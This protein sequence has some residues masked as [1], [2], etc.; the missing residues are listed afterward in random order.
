MRLR[1]L[2]KGPGGLKYMFTGGKGG[3][4][5]TVLA[6]GLAAHFAM[7]GEKTLVASLNPV[8]SLSSLFQQELTGGHVKPVRGLD[9]LYAIEVEID[10]AV[11]A[12]RQSISKRLRE[13]LKWAEIPLNPE[14]FIDIATTN[15]AFHE[16]AMF[17]KTM[18]IVTREAG[19]YS[20]IIFDTAAVANAVRLIGLSKIYGLWLRRMIESRKE[21]MSLR[22]Q[23]S[24]KKDKVAEEIKRDPLMLDLIKMNERFTTTRKILTNPEETAFFFVT[25]P[26][27]LPIS[28]VKRFISMVKAFEI[29][30]GGV[31]VNQI[32]PEQA[33]RTDG[34]GFLNGKREEQR[35]YMQMIEDDMGDLV[36]SYVRMFPREIV[37]LD[38]ITQVVDDM[39]NYEPEAS[40][41][42]RLG[43]DAVR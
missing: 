5:K 20:R 25:T 10:D 13:F 23:L 4:G 39:L 22:L 41:L 37:G 42:G 40:T 38:S 19:S 14:P 31:M 34:S 35:R 7:Q 24:V 16:S 11:D 3:V 9:N 17:D 8:H 36:V 15:P 30:V 27:S 18:D 21:A 1:E 33:F 28:V 26:Q 29:P 43:E 6:A 12:Y 32:F 2:L